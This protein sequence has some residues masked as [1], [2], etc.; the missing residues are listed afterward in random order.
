M[1]GGREGSDGGVGILRGWRGRAAVT[2]EGKSLLGRQAEEEGEER[3]GRNGGHLGSVCDT[4]N[5]VGSGEGG[6]GGEA[7]E[8]RQVNERREGGRTD[9]RQI[10]AD[11][12]PGI[13]I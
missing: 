5:V 12:A 6:G 1:R 11:F 10:P 2:S 8:A 7:A 3:G 4:F 9:G 13:Y